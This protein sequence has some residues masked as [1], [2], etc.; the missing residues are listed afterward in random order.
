[1]KYILMDTNIYLDL[2]V[3][4]R[5][6]VS[7]NLV[8]NFKNLL[9]FDE[10]KL[11]VPQIVVH[12][13]KKHL[14]TQFLSVGKTLDEAISSIDKIH[15]ICGLSTGTLNAEL[16]KKEA[17]KQIKSL[18]EKFANNK[19]VYLESITELIETIFTHNNC[20]IVDDDDKIRSLCLKR[21]IYKKAPFHIDGKESFADGTIAV[22][23]IHLKEYI[24]FSEQDSIIFVTGN[25]S[26]FSE[27]GNKR[28][29]HKDILEDLSLHNMEKCTTYVI[30]FN[31]L[32][33][34]VLETE[35]DSA[36]LQEE[37]EKNL[38]REA[39]EQKAQQLLEFIDARRATVGLSSLSG[40]EDTFI[41]EFNESKFVL[42]VIELFERL[43]TCYSD[44][45]NLFYFYDEDMLGYISSFELDDIQIFI[46]Q[47]NSVAEQLDFPEVEANIG[48]LVKIVESIKDKSA[49]LDFSDICK[50]LPDFIEFG[51]EESFYAFDKNKYELCLDELCLSCQ[52]GGMDWLDVAL[53]KNDDEILA[54]GTIEIFYGYADENYDGTVG[55]SCEQLIDYSTSDVE[56]EL[57]R[58]IDEFETWVFEE[59]K[60]MEIIQE[61]LFLVTK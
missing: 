9:D 33:G 11:V 15:D 42:S 1:M 6:N 61:K 17:R 24:D 53:I 18:Q 27:K 4:R 21:R 38:Q 2:I 40:F 37:F 29:L 52:E 19:D 51:K 12:E 14:E 7:S 60:K 58:I 35:V 34:K 20:I 54:T 16:H 50:T 8:S 43:N 23:L 32:V 13:V 47:W 59:T 46:N 44:L 22:T 45:E 49:S 30:S 5:H 31:E 55:D 25:T 3:D 28:V 48:G 39:A 41:E 36:N 57:T 56:N 26:D 10:I